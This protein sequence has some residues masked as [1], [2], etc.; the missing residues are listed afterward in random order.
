MIEKLI[1]CIQC[2]QVI[3]RW[4][5][6]G[7]SMGSDFFP[8]VEWS[9]EDFNHQKNFHESHAHH[10]IE[11]LSVDSDTWVSEKPGYEPMKVS[12][13]EAG[14][15][16]E[17]F[18][19]RRTKNALDQPAFYELIPGKLQVSNVALKIQEKDLANQMSRRNGTPPWPEDKIKKFIELF[20][21][22]V[23]SIPVNKSGNEIETMHEGETPLLAYGTLK[24]SHWEKLLQRCE[25]NFPDSDLEKIKKFIQANK[26]P[27]HVLALQIQRE[28][29]IVTPK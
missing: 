29:S 8:Q 11:E 13:F 10:T 5:S 19:I 18:L 12:Y 21:E 25:K 3:P 24:E 6:D 20:R 27:D 14:N 15:G 28:I 17:R 1:R 9:T 7:N 23:A 26:Q 16:R 22:E 2:N 4:G